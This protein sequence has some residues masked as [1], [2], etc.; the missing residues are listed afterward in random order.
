MSRG[1][2]SQFPTPKL[3]VNNHFENIEQFGEA[4]GWDLDFRQMDPGPLSAKVILIGHEFVSVVRFELSRSFHQIG[5]PPEGRM[6]FGLP[7]ASSGALKWNGVE[8]PPGVLI[9]FNYEAMLDCVSP[10][11]FSGFVLSFKPEA[12]RIAAENLGLSPDFFSELE[13]RRFWDPTGAEH[14]QLRHLLSAMELVALEDDNERLELWKNVFNFDIATLLVRIL[15]MNNLPLP[16]DAPNFRTSAMNRALNI[17]KDYP[18]NPV[19]VE[20]LCQQVDVSWA[21][22]ERAFAEEF[23]VTPNKYIKLRRL[24]AVQSDLIKL[25]PDAVISDVANKWAF[26]HMGSF[27]SDYRKQFGELPSQTLRSLEPK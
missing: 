19:N 3:L 9:N 14:R 20:A 16:H 7:D 5:R 17:L 15:A 1:K 27:A 6:T 11:P 26:W 21:T 13:S 25:G 24:A 18:N 22:L 4:I 12:L 23:G 8:T 2:M 10:A